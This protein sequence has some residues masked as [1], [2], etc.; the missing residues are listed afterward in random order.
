M[1]NSEMKTIIRHID[2][3]T[4]NLNTRGRR[5]YA[6]GPDEQQRRNIESAALGVK[7]WARRTLDALFDIQSD[8]KTLF[9]QMAKDAEFEQI[10]KLAKKDID[11]LKTVVKALNQMMAF[12]D[13]G[14]KAKVY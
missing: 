2:R 3:L 10:K 7:N 11:S 12:C 5:R 1:K 8:C 6:D 14:I 9:P 13:E 4:R